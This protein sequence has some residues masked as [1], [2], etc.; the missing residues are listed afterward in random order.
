VTAVVLI[1]CC[2]PLLFYF[3]RVPFTSHLPSLLAVSLLLFLWKTPSVSQRLRPLLMGLAAALVGMVRQQ[4]LAIV[5]LLL[6]FAFISDRMAGLTWRE[7][8]RFLALFALGFFSL[9]S[10]QMITWRVLTGSLLTYSYQGFGFD[11]WK[12]PKVMDVLFSSNHGLFSWHPFLLVSLAGLLFA[13]KRCRDVGAFL[14]ASFVATLYVT[15]SWCCWW[16]AHSFGHRAFIGLT[17][18]FVFGLGAILTRTRNSGLRRLVYGV[19]GVLF[20]WNG[21]LMLAYLS[22][23]IP[24]EG[25]FSWWSLIR[26]LP[27]LFDQIG[28]KVGGL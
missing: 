4:D 28:D 12:N 3:I 1:W 6:G 27:G 13:P 14:A 21:V 25:E 20:A 11:H 16:L 23:M 5:A 18:V 9:F 19:G 22:E 26:R 2:S 24:Y 7:T 17:P 10:L 15:S 8:R